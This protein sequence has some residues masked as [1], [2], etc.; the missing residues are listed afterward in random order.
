MSLVRRLNP[1]DEIMDEALMNTTGRTEIAE[2]MREAKEDEDAK[3]KA[4][5]NAKDMKE[6]LA[7]EREQKEQSLRD[8]QDEAAM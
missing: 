6:K 8:T 2:K 7:D 1:V 3:E 4:E 5:K